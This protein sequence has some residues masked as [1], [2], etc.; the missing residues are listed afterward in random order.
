MPEP[1]LT[2]TGRSFPCLCYFLARMSSC[3]I[4]NLRHGT[5]GELSH[6]FTRTSS[7]TLSSPTEGILRAHVA[8]YDQFLRTHLFI[9]P[10]LHPH[11]SLL[12]FSLVDHF[13]YNPEIRR[14]KCSSLLHLLQLLQLLPLLLLHHGTTTYQLRTKHCGRLQKT[15]ARRG[16]PS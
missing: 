15:D 3:K 11:Q 16:I 9:H 12:Q 4:L 13:V 7:P 1:N 8:C 14:L 6:L 2:M 5:D 10:L